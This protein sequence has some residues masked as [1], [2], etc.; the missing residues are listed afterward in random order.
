MTVRRS[1]GQQEAKGVVSN[2]AGGVQVTVV[3]A[4]TGARPHPLGERKLA[5]DSPTNP[6]QARR[7][8]EASY[9]H[10]M[11]SV[12]A[13]LVGQLEAEL[14]PSRIVNALA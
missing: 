2:V 12:P 5:I 8:E 13:G 1:I 14:R 9:R 11:L 3:D 7:R 4:A 6:A 10:Q